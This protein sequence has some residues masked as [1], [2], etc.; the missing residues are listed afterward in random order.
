MNKSKINLVAELGINA[1]GDLVKVLEM[2][3]A[4]KKAG[5]DYVKFQ[6]RN[7]DMCIPEHQKNK[8]KKVPWRDKPGTYLQYKKDIELNEEYG[9]IDQYCKNVGIPWFASVWDLDSAQFMRQFDLDL[10]KIPSALMTD[11]ILI[12]RCKDLF[13]KVM[14][15][16]G[17]STQSEIENMVDYTRPDILMHTNACY[18]TKFENINLGYMYQLQ[19]FKTFINPLDVGYSNHCPN[20]LA[21]YMAAMMNVVKW[22]EVHVT[23][24]SSAWGSDQKSSFE[25]RKMGLIID[26]IRLLKQSNN[27]ILNKGN[28]V[29]ELYDGEIIKRKSLRG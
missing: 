1:N 9:T 8:E 3:D 20:E 10:I 23:L 24:N 28:R 22:I 26:N 2:I 17:M 5:F 25:L 6:K 16:T 7:P 15:S 13:P 11:H 27:N 12:K 19:Y 18:P 4:S 21:L 14:V 29:R